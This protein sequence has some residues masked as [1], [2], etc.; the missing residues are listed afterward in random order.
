MTTREKRLATVV[1]VVA[2]VGI[3]A[4]VVYPV[5]V[6]PLFDVEDEIGRLQDDLFEVQQERDRI[7][8]A[9]LDYKGLVERTGST[10]PEKVKNALHTQL[11]GMLRRAGLESQESRVT[12]KK[13]IRDRKTGVHTVSLTIA[14]E[15]KLQRMV[16]FLEKCYELPHVSRFKDVKLS[17]AG[18]KRRQKERDLVKLSATFETLLLPRDP[19]ARGL[20]DFDSLDQPAELI[21]HAG[22][23]YAMIW[24]RQ[25]FNEY[26][27]DKPVRR[28]ERKPEQ[29]KEPAE[30]LTRKASKPSGDPNRRDKY[31]AGVLRGGTRELMVINRKRNT[32]EYVAQGGQIDGGRLLYVHPLGGIVRKG[33]GDYFYELGSLLS[34]AVPVKDAAD[35]PGLQLVAARLPD[36]VP[37]EDLESPGID[38]EAAEPAGSS[39]AGDTT[40]S[41]AEADE[42]R[43]S[44][45]PGTKASVK[46]PGES[47]KR[48]IKPRSTRARPPKSGR[49]GR[50]RAGRRPGGPR[51]SAARKSKETGDAS[52]G[53]PSPAAQ[54]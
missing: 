7:D 51:V 44:A 45:K 1:G 3:A 15:G 35:I 30:E 32:R 20:I 52:P 16:E 36:S 8:D 26:V 18:R 38:L 29:T 10:D 40:A 13:P 48:S 47:Q 11:E 6:K 31:V 39:E 12:P 42:G 23:S 25:P 28:A 5:A 2:A 46:T 14:A 41:P 49:V 54:E 24:E 21:K 17:P 19:L 27:K 34:E 33:D 9:L 43:P 37:F 53:G 22:D 4:K 50:R